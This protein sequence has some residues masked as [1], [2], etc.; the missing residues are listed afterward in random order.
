MSRISA[1]EE[2]FNAA[3]QP[4]QD[5]LNRSGYNHTLEYSK[6]PE[7]KQKNRKKN[8]TWFNPP[9]SLNVKTNIGREF[10]S[11]VD[12][13]FPPDN[14]LSKLFNRQTVKVSY[15]RMPNLSQAVAGHNAKLLA[16][17]RQAEQLGCNCIGGL[18]TCPVDGNCQATGVVYQ[19]SVTEL[20][21][22]QVETY[23]GTTARRFKDRLYEH[24]TNMNNE[25]GRTETALSAHIWS[26]KDQGKQYE[27]KWK[28][29]CRGSDYN[30][31]TKK[32]RICL[33]EKHFIMYDRSGCSLNKR[34][35][36][37]NTC[38]HKRT[39]LLENVKT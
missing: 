8:I 19:A 32:C 27:V 9:F 2:I 17:G 30:P 29:R 39:K 26:L 3:K 22:G 20:G 16:G 34:S 33:R 21:S 23:T 6:P 37:F 7:S 24:N 11:L 25:T 36:V 18:P 31:R 1:N 15:K 13:A 28:I 5:A 35:E 12:R 10:L 14:P 38:R 4:Y